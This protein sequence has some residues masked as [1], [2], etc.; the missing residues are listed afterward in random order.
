MAVLF[1]I[2]QAAGTALT[3]AGTIQQGRAARAAGEAEAIAAGSRATALRQQAGQER[4]ISQR[5]AIEERRRGEFVT[6]RAQALAA[7]SGAGALDPTIVGILGDLE[8]ETEFRAL[9]ALYEG[10]QA[11]RGLEFGAEGELFAGE[12]ARRAGRAAQRR[13][14]LKAGGQFLEGAVSLR[15]P[16]RRGLHHAPNGT[17]LEGGESLYDK[18][19]K[20]FG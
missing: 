11:A 20:G 8:T 17:L 9:T 19:A 7:A 2:I 12:V 16:A 13:S 4:A 10:E 18:Y 14:F 6:S 1:P 5:G 15:Y 3:I